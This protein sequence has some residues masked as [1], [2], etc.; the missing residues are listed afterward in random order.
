M[1]PTNT[2]EINAERLWATIE[3]S[4]EIGR[5]RDT[6]LRR[7]ALSREDKEVRDLFASWA[8]DAGCTVEVDPVG[9]IFARRPGTD[10]TLPPVA[11]GSHLDT[12]ICGG[13]YDGVLGVMCG[14]EAIRT[15]NDRAVQTS[16]T[17]PYR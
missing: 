8:R 13:Q 14:S 4:G 7:L 11:I 15:L 1:S 9:N 2:L 5:F 12:Q 10:S 17:K 3:R 16:A 6:G